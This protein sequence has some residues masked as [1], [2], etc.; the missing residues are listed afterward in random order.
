MA[1]TQISASE[2][3]SRAT[4]NE[5]IGGYR[6]TSQRSP[7]FAW[8]EG[9]SAERFTVTGLSPHAIWLDDRS[10]H[11]MHAQPA[12][13]HGR[14]WLD[15]RGERLGPLQ[16]ELCS[17]VAPRWLRPG[18][19]G[20]AGLALPSGPLS[21][22]RGLAS[23]LR[24][25][26][27]TAIVGLPE[28]DDPGSE[29][30]TDPVALEQLLDFMVRAQLTGR[31]QTTR[32]E[33]PVT[34]VEGGAA[35]PRF[36]ADARDW[37]LPSTVDFEHLNTIYQVP[38]SAA[39]GPGA[40]VAPSWIRKLGQ[41]RA[42]RARA[43]HGLRI[44]FVHPHSPELNLDAPLLD[45]SRSGVSFHT[46]AA[47][48]LIYPGLALPELSLSWHG[49]ACGSFRGSVRSVRF[50]RDD[51]HAVVGLS[52][53]PLS[54][55]D[56]VLLREVLD[57]LLYPST[58][59]SAEDVWN[60]F[61][62]SGYL[63]L[64][65]KQPAAFAHLRAP[66]ARTA[67]AFERAP[68]VATLAHWP[69]RGEL[70]ATLSHLKLYE[71]SWL[72]CQVSKVKGDA[73][74]ASGRQ[75][76]SDMY[77]RIYESAHTDPNT[78]WLIVYV[79]DDAPRWSRELHVELPRR[80]LASGEACILPFRALEVDVAHAQSSQVSDG[81]KV[82]AADAAERTAVARS[83]SNIRPHHYLDA[84]DLCEERID[85]AQ[86]CE[87]WQRAGLERSRQILV[88]H[89]GSLRLAAAVLETAPEGAHLY[90]LLDCLRMYPLRPG[91]E[92]GFA[93]LLQRA[94]AWFAARGR[95][96]FT[97]LEEYPNTLPARTRAGFRDLGGATF[98]I[99]AVERT[100][101]L[102]QRAADLAVWRKKPQL[103]PASAARS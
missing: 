66:F 101:E 14:L 89:E 62:A 68:D 31:V 90:G 29:L 58:K 26:E 42:R 40:S 7:L 1:K 85:L 30:V 39:A 65:H 97:Y 49:R 79:Q 67:E 52:L 60:V 48:Q 91:G 99:L 100:P 87:R 34:L 84:L 103:S 63:H 38:V 15:S 81:I 50:E 88:A 12:P 83:L 33:A 11:P 18:A 51:R 70:S 56:A 55:T 19:G 59:G 22:L 73:Q 61:E 9:A 102:L 2:L 20:I 24:A 94:H 53:E 93:Q 98:S 8:F 43:P 27:R 76:L 3:S 21:E 36:S 95:S 41:R 32:G 13:L 78:R 10:F 57:P 86:A 71:T 44:A 75:G 74:G 80:Y 69:A 45:L 47:E 17:A 4:A 23:Y 77:L 46:D 5:L 72:L 37:L 25:L 16:V 54:Q 35:G 96:Q 82:V 28:Q 6:V 64:S 92:R